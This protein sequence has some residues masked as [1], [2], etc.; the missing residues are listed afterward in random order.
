MV[1]ANKGRSSVTEAV[2]DATSSRPSRRAKEVAAAK[3]NHSYVDPK[4][5]EDSDIE[6]EEEDA[7][8][9]EQSDD[10]ATDSKDEEFE[11]SPKKSS[12]KRKGASRMKTG[13]KE[14]AGS[15]GGKKSKKRKTVKTKLTSESSLYA[16]LLAEDSQLVIDS[17]LTKY[18]EEQYVATTEILSLFVR[19][20]GCK[21]EV[22]VDML[23]DVQKACQTLTE[24]FDEDSDAYVQH[25]VSSVCTCA[26]KARRD[27]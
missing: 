17:W 16:G 12:S 2:A 3:L 27:F 11:D 15:S 6:E 19:C 20:C 23:S 26:A 14:N 9:E 25:P 10:S 22:T 1:R 4:D 13:A 18:E 21:E 7:V 5:E 24:N 8:A